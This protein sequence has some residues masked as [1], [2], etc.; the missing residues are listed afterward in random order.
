LGRLLYDGGVDE[1]APTNVCVTG[2]TTLHGSV[3]VPGDK[4]V[5]HRA[6]LL[7]ALSHGTS[8]ITGLSNGADVLHTKAAITTLGAAVV[9]NPD[10]SL[11]VTG[12]ALHEPAEVIDVGNSG[13][14]IRLIAGLVAGLD[15]V[16]VLQGDASIGR[17]PMDRI[18]IPLRQ[19][20]AQVDGRDHGRY[21]PLIIR[22][23]ALHG[24]DY[25]PPV[26]SAQVKS[27][28]LL[29]GLSADS[30]T[31]IREPV[32]SRAHTEEMLTVRGAD[33]DVD[34]ATVRLRPSTLTAVDEDVPGDPSQA[35]FWLVGAAALAG[36]E[37]TV[38]GIYLGHARGGFLDV[39]RRMGADVTTN[40][41][42]TVARAWDV[43]IRSAHLTATDIEPHE[44]AGLVDE[45]PALAVA[46]ALADGTTTIRG[47]EE[48]RV[49]ESDRVATTA[50]MLRAFGV[51]VDE[52]PDGLVI[53]GGSPLRPGVV[54]S[55]GD[56]RIA[57]AAA[58][59]ALA[60]DGQ[61]SISGFEAV[62]TSY[63]DFLETL[64]SVAASDPL[65]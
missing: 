35:A 3:R 47:A 18:A 58:I 44:I 1:P 37:V 41:S 12:G 62:D 23:G 6:L 33:L 22:G 51:E 16:T 49:K 55:H 7:S 57:M 31:I 29:G 38:E 11:D 24:I 15:G 14:G 40:A 17:R 53:K 19:L 32:R 9:T 61:S 27:A 13:T 45:I 59:L 63:P 10:G 43:T 64:S 5:S 50:A 21:A 54:D 39:L 65:V 26:S 42:A 25:T 2:P 28:I 56:H 48:L 36:S 4:S 30:E 8:H 34:G 46:A 60:A 20:G 52:L